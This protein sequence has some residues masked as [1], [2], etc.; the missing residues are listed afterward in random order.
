M[1]GI[2]PRPR[3]CQATAPSL[4][5]NPA[6]HPQFL[7]RYYW[8]LL[9]LVLVLVLANSY[10]SFILGP[11][12]PGNALVTLPFC[13]KAFNGH[14]WFSLRKPC[15]M[16]FF[17]QMCFR[18]PKIWLWRGTCC[19][20]YLARFSLGSLKFSTEFHHILEYPYGCLAPVLLGSGTVHMTLSGC[21]NKLGGAS[22]AS[23][24][25]VRVSLSGLLPE[26][27]GRKAHFPLG[28]LR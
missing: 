20:S 28:P 25:G 11:Q 19:F 23:E 2:K 15:A 21:G 18:N 14:H 24:S 22:E 12:H 3:A 6:S 17:F 9:V 16:F 7:F 8:V 5:C 27:L 26:R 10:L 13:V 1:L 4:G